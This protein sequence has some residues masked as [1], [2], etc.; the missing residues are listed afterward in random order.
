[1]CFEVGRTESDERV[2]GRVRLWE[3]IARELLDQREEPF[4][5]ARRDA[6][7]ARSRQELLP[8]GDHFFGFLLAHGAAQHVGFSERKPRGTRGNLHHVFLI[9]NHAVGFFEDFFQFGQVVFDAFA[10]ELASDEIVDHAALNGP[11]PVERVQGR[12]VGQARGLGAP[13]DVRH[14]A[15]FKL[16]DARRQ[17]LAEELIGLGVV[18]RP[19]VRVHF[20]A[21]RLFNELQA[22]VNHCEGPQAQEVHLQEA[23]LLQVFHRILGCDFVSAAFVKRNHFLEGCRGNDHARGVRGG[24][25]RQTLQAQRDFHQLADARLLVAQLPEFRR[26]L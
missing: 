24:V 26:L 11:G 6:A 9:D 14:P 19:G 18:E 7:L 17:A 13:K 4:R 10:S 1:M 5:F 2:S 16:E 23:N 22:V 20:L 3:A 25:A 21:A 12:Q 8:H 15:A